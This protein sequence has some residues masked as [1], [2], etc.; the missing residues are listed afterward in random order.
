MEV[1]AN[2]FSALIL[3]PPPEMRKIMPRFREPTLLHVVE[4][5]RHFCVSKDAAARSYASYHEQVVAIVIVKDGRILRCY[6][7]SKFP[8][9]APSYGQAVPADTL[10][11]RARSALNTTSNF[12]EVDAVHWLEEDRRY[13]RTLYEQTYP[14]QNGYAMIL[15]LLEVDDGEDGDEERSI[16]D[17]WRVGFGRRR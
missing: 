14:Q 9:I 2:R 6:K 3:M 10:F 11:H 17:G 16:E 12:A 7:Q 13:R 4:V 1:E 8:R 15:L 5:A